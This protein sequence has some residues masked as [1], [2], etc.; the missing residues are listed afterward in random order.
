MEEATVRLFGLALVWF[1]LV[2]FGLVWLVF[3]F[4]YF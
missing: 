3:P 1:G 4:Y 2:W